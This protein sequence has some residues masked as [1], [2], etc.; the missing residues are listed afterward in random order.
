MA[1]LGACKWAAVR[2]PA[3]VQA[4]RPHTGPGSSRR[5]GKPSL[6]AGPRPPRP[7]RAWSPRPWPPGRSWSRSGRRRQAQ[8]LANFQGAG[9]RRRRGPGAASEA[10]QLCGWSINERGAQ[11]QFLPSQNLE[12]WLR[13]PAA[14]CPEGIRSS[15]DDD[16]SALRCAEQQHSQRRRPHQRAAA[17]THAHPVR[18]TVSTLQQNIVHP[19]ADHPCQPHAN[20]HTRATGLSMPNQRRP[21][22]PASLGAAH[23]PSHPCR[24]AHLLTICCALLPTFTQNTMSQAKAALAHASSPLALAACILAAVVLTALLVPAA[25]RCAAGP[26]AAL[27]T[28]QQVRWL[29]TVAECLPRGCC[30]PHTLGTLGT[31]RWAAAV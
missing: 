23:H 19:R 11:P 4:P 21:R 12:N 17:P 22:A 6:W 20:Y 29:E 25:S 27:A 1:G 31:C 2:D 15:H 13:L 5:S 24:P 26:R 7:R 3:S 28:C 9:C 18:P 8:G 16:R 14:R 10:I 30:D